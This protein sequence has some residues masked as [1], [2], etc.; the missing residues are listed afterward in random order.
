MVG[1]E[2]VWLRD[3]VAELSGGTDPVY[4]LEGTAELAD[5][6][7]PEFVY[8][9]VTEL[10]G[11][12][13]YPLVEPAEL[14]AIEEMGKEVLVASVVV[15]SEG[16]T[17]TLPELVGVTPDVVMMTTGAEGVFEDVTTTGLSLEEEAMY[18]LEVGALEAGTLEAGVFEAGAVTAPEELGKFGIVIDGVSNA[19]EEG[20]T[21]GRTLV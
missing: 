20:A 2:S 4:E 8:D 3:A 15:V 19:L 12:I 16:T 13:V 7:E 18:P 9:G 11:G 21:V 10:G 5:E 14:G 6:T 1:T 17:M